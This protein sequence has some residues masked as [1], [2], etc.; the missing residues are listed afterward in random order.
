MTPRDPLSRCVTVSTTA[1]GDRPMG[2][3]PGD[4]AL[5]GAASALGVDVRTPRALRERSPYR[6]VPVSLWLMGDDP[7]YVSTQKQA[8]ELRAV[9]RS[10]RLVTR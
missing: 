3:D 4:D 7:V 6:S 2:T 8:D 1:S 9:D 10:Y 5:Q